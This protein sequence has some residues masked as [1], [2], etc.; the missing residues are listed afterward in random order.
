MVGLKTTS[1]LRKYKKDMGLSSSINHCHWLISVKSACA[2]ISWLGTHPECEMGI[3]MTCSCE[4]FKENYVLFTCS[5]EH[6]QV[7][8]KFF[9]SFSR[10]IFG[11]L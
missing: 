4:V 8:V 11:I 7:T 3:Y 10:K 5:L 2:L 1:I 6:V 9:S